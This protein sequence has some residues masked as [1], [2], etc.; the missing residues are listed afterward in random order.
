MTSPQHDFETA[1][2]MLLV[3]VGL[4]LAGGA[5][6]GLAFLPPATLQT[7]VGILGCIVLAVAAWL[8][9]VAVAH[10]LRGMQ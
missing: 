10:A 5:L 1:G 9:M 4:G 6:I 3:A 7:G 2:V 8:L